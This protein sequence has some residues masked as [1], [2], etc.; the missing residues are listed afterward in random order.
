MDEEYIRRILG[1]VPLSG[2]SQAYNAMQ[3]QQ[4]LQNAPGAAAATAGATPPGQPAPQQQ[5]QPIGFGQFGGA[6]N[7][8]GMGGLMQLLQQ[9][10]GQGMGGI[11]GLGR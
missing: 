9:R 2:I 6:M 7:M 5:G 11:L 8:P 1:Y 3:P 4:T 10:G